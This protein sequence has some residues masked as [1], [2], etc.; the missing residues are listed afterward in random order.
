MKI[1]KSFT[2]TILCICILVSMQMSCKP[3]EEVQKPE[4]VVVHYDTLSLVRGKWETD[5]VHIAS[6]N[7]EICAYMFIYWEMSTNSWIV[8][9]M[10]PSITS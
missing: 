3:T 1:N 8:S 7:G 10:E 5:I 9:L 4:P 2:Y 6:S